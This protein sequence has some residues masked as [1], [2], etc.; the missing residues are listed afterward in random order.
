MKA[1]PLATA[2]GGVSSLQVGFRAVLTKA[3]EKGIGMT[4]VIRWMSYNT[5]QFAR[6]H[7]RGEIAPGKRADMAIIRPGERF[8]VDAST[9]KSRNPISAFDGMVLNGVIA[10]TFVS[11]KGTEAV[12]GNLIARP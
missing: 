7:D 6:L 11:G 9:L 3:S 10:R 2:W 5:A 4:D 8:T 12:Q 1:G